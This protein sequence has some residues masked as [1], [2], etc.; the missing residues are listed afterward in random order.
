MDPGGSEFGWWVRVLAYAAFASIGGFMGH[1]M[2]TMNDEKKIHWGRAALE[3]V[4]AGF[5]GLLMLFACQALNLSEQWVGVI[6]GVSGW[7]GANATIRIL[8]SLV[9]QKLGLKPKT[10]EHKDEDA[11]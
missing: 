10:T 9:F 4:S 3:G 7:L 6:V 5:V 2:R 11:T 8:E 1:I